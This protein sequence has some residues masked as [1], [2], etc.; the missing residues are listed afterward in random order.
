MEADLKAALAERYPADE[1][2]GYADGDLRGAFT[3]TIGL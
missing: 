3:V 2:T 1:A